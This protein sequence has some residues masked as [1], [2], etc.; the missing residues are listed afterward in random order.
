M[1]ALLADAAV[2]AGHDDAYRPLYL[3]PNP[4][5]VWAAHTEVDWAESLASDDPD[6]AVAH[7]RLALEPA[8]GNDQAWVARRA[9]AV[10]GQ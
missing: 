2:T 6:G 8:E 3:A 9:R 1:L 4:S 10:L 5:P 7:A